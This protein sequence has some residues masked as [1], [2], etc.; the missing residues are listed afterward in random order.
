M[1]CR[2]PNAGGNGA[3]ATPNTGVAAVGS[4]MRDSDDFN[5]HEDAL[6]MLHSLETSP[7]SGTASA[8]SDGMEKMTSTL[9]SSVFADLDV[10]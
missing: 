4:S 6:H 7:R 8:E 3:S 2:S 5:A 1:F 10:V 9:V